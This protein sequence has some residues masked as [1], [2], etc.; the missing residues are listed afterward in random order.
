MDMQP[1]Q[2]HPQYTEMKA[3][4][5][6][7]RDC[8]TGLRALHKRGSVYLPRLGGQTADS[9]VH[10]QSYL[11]RAQYFNAVGRTIDAMSGYVFRKQPTITLPES[12]QAYAKDI[13]FNGISLEGF[14]SSLVE[15]VIE[16]G[17][18]GVLVEYPQREG[19]QNGA[20]L[21]IND[22]QKMGLR[23]YLTTYKTEDV[24]NWRS[25]KVN[26][27][28]MLVA[29]FL[30]ELYDEDQTQ[31]RE[32]Y[33][34]DGYKQ[35][36]WRKDA[37]KGN[38]IVFA[39]VNPMLNGASIPYIPFFPVGVKE[40]DIK[41]QPPPLEGLAD[42]CLGYYRNS[43]D[44]ENAL[45]VVGTPTPWVNGVDDPEKVPEMHI[46]SN[47]F[48]KLPRDSEAGYLQCGADGVA[49]LK[50]AMQEKKLEMAA[51]GARMLDNEKRAAESAD[52]QSIKRGGE[53]SI[54]ASLAGS[55]EMTVTKALRF[56]AEWIGINPDQ[57]NV[58]L[59][60][61]YIPSSIDA[62]MLREYRENYL[63]N[64]WSF[65]T[66]WEACIAGEIVR[67]GLTYEDEID[68]KE[69]NP[70]ALGALDDDQ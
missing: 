66:F 43:A 55:V 36:I 46:G 68:R 32:L 18:A 50:E 4:W 26:N 22:S 33:L 69:N 21:T 19:A 30:K 40:A 34:E 6:K 65:E 35:R 56:M 13:D 23:P 62:N 60:K 2:E 53:N 5:A 27:A 16:V 15:E 44:Y 70:V 48:L 1:D 45:H 31:I 67:E 25:A 10:Y 28:T 38:W 59:N 20:R 51:Q 8:A 58:E 7:M 14:L 12:M 24:I 39:V 11:K 41:V 47:T 54:L 52:A 9:D 17:R 64:A 57:V 3:A 29:V 63:T 37:D 42:T 49:A 61:D